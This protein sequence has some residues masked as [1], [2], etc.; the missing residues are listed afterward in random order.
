L[1]H[2][3]PAE[4]LNGKFLPAFCP[5]TGKHTPSR[6]GRLARKEAVRSRALLFLRIVR[7]RHALDGSTGIAKSKFYELFT[8]NPQRRNIC[9]FDLFGVRVNNE[10][11]NAAWFGPK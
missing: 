7:C 4:L 3:S 10:L 6:W 9:L 1:G 8:G 11:T 2:K 5:A